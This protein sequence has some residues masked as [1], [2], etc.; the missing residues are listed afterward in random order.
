MSLFLLRVSK[1]PGENKAKKSKQASQ[2]YT[3]A[4]LHE[5]GVLIEI[6]DLQTNQLVFTLFYITSYIHLN[7]MHHIS[8]F[9]TF[10]RFKN[11]IFEISPSDVV[12]V[13]DIKAKFMGVHLETLLL[14]YQVKVFC[15]IT[16][17]SCIF[18]FCV[19]FSHFMYLIFPFN[20]IISIAGVT[21]VH[22]L[23]LIHRIFC[24]YSMRA[25]PS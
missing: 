22:V 20:I 13:F 3:A 5:K 23:F 21:C 11:V 15:N 7:N 14:E 12:G 1:K 25:W 18:G 6:E 8:L 10:H 2:K 24:N 9:S 17:I 19:F 16:F 4:R